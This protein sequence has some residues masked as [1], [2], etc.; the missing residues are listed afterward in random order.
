M[1]LAGVL[2]SGYLSGQKFFTR[3]CAFNEPCPYFLGHP[4][5]YYGFGIFVLLFLLAAFKPAKVYLALLSFVGIIF[6]GGL[7]AGE[8]INR[9]QST[10]PV[11]YSL[12]LP[13]C[14]YGLV[15]Y[16]IIFI[17]SVIPTKQAEGAA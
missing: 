4:A 14:A 17:L 16:L 13:T 9:L 3:V 7:V 10:A 12:G 5:C 2:F 6:A 8:I 11:S 15:F 1:T